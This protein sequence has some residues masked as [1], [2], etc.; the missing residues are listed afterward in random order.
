MRYYPNLI[1]LFET[2]IRNCVITHVCI[3]IDDCRRHVDEWVQSAITTKHRR[4]NHCP[5]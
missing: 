2:V 3:S 4:E 1:S 5:I